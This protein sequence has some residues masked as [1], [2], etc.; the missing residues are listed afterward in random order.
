MSTADR[1]RRFADA[2]A[3][4]GSPCYE[5]WALG[6]AA[7]GELLALL[8]DLPVAK[9]QPNLLFAAA[10]YSGIPA[11]PFPDFRRALLADWPAVRKVMLARRTQT[12]EPGRCAVLLP[13]LAALPQP[14]ALLEVGA[15]AGLCLYPD[16][17]SY[18]YGDHPRL[19]PPAGPARA[20]LDC[21]I[22]GPVPIPA[23]LPRVVWR[24]GI[25]LNPL[26]VADADD[27]RWLEA[28]IWPEHDHRRAR[29]TPAIEIAKAEPAHIVTG[30]LNEKLTTLAA[31][32]P[33]EATL[34]VFH[35]A[36]LAYLDAESR[37][38][39]VDTVRGLNARWIANEGPGALPVTAPPSPEPERAL[40]LLTLDSEPVAYSAGHGQTLHWL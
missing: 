20:V 6:V 4:G 36:V 29:L 2:E 8:D 27:V 40:F 23:A 33:R 30:D 37:A 19:D 11:G 5:E 3:R 13:L 35:S 26:D 9:R 22:T 31:A 18:R 16:R 28:L 15:S 1:Y 25:D 17:Y 14:L 21:E 32:A 10:R 12:N 34:V 24:A 39:F 38:E 7:D